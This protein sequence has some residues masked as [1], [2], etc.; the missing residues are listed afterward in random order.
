MRR[1]RCR[2]W[3]RQG[4]RRRTEKKRES[5]RFA[6]RRGWGEVIAMSWMPPCPQIPNGEGKT[7]PTSPTQLTKDCTTCSILLLTRQI[8]LTD[9]HSGAKKRILQGGT[10]KSKKKKYPHQYKSTLTSSVGQQKSFTGRAVEVPQCL[11]SKQHHITSFC[12]S[13]VMAY[14]HCFYLVFSSY[15]WFDTQRLCQKKNIT[16]LFISRDFWCTEYS[17]KR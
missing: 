17:L 16:S 11:S 1:V 13:W 10:N 8:P 7:T 5:R 6:D 12:E 9:S 4:K 3:G 14:F 2:L 15:C